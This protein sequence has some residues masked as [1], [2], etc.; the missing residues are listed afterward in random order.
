M[1]DEEP[2]RIVFPLDFQKPRI[3]TAPIRLMPV[4]LEVVALADV[5]AAIRS[6][7]AKVF[8][9][10]VDALRSFAALLYRGLVSGNS[11]IC[12]LCLVKT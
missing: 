1:D 10:F 4:L 11:R 3:V 2:V 8:D 6:H 5:C 9:A 12:Q 7:C